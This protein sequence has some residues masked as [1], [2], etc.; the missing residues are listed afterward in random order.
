[1]SKFSSYYKDELLKSKEPSEDSRTVVSGGELLV[2]KTQTIVEK[3][4][5]IC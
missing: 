4:P 2:T 1:M 3:P 5:S